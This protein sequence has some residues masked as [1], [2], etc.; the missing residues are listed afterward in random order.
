MNQD[1]WF[2][3]VKKADDACLKPAVN[4][5]ETQPLLSDSFNKTTLDKNWQI[6]GECVPDKYTQTSGELVITASGTKVDDCNPLTF[7][8]G[9]HSYEISVK[10]T[11]ND[12]QT[13]AG[14]ILQ[15]NQNISNGI[16]I[17]DRRPALYRLGRALWRGQ[18]LDSDEFW[19]KMIN[20]NQYLS[21]YYST[22]GASCKKISR[23]INLIPQNNNAYGGF[24]SLRPGLFAFGEGM[25]RFSNLCYNDLK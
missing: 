3:V 23:V 21:C 18:K 16:A 4:A 17:E 1:G 2:K 20:N 13:S 24:L 5:L 6:F 25:V 11:L 10:L 7:I 9:G 14:L 19:L 22:D 8:T 12:A 15:Y